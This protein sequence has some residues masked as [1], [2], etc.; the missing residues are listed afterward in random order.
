V[1][2]PVIRTATD[3]DLPSLAGLRNEFT[4]EGGPIGSPREDFHAAFTEIVG[5][6]LRDGRWTVWLA[7]VDGSIASHAFVGLIDKI[8]Q[9]TRSV[10]SRVGYL[11]NVYTVPRFRNQGLGSR[12]LEAV[13]AWALAEDV[14][15]LVVW[16]SEESVV[17]YRRHGFVGES[18]P[19]VWLNPNASG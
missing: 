9:P 5:S 11:T 15:L 18:E 14:E 6:G 8:P 17:F 19:F 2:A 10:G 7:E 4:L 13:K 16:P 12:V 1:G 3:Q